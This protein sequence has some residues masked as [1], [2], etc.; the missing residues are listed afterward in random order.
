MFRQYV[1]KMTLRVF[2]VIHMMIVFSC[3]II[4]LCI[5]RCMEVI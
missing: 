5:F 2:F 1:R 3:G 4:I